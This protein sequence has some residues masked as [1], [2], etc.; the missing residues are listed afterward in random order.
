MTMPFSGYDLTLLNWLNH[1]LIPDSVPVL[2]II[3]LS[4][5][6]ISIS[7][8]LVVL[9]LSI[10]KRSKLLRKQFLILASVLI[11]GAIVTQGLKASIFRDRPFKT[12]PVIEKLSEGGDSSFP[13]GHTIESFA[14]AM[15]LSLLFSKKKTV[16]PVYLWAMTVAYSRM[17]LGVHYPS[18]VLAGVLIGTFIG[19]IIP[20]IFNR[21]NPSG[22]INDPMS[23]PGLS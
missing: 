1:H 17:A 19:W 3:S 13:S 4:T 6:F 15:A 23:Q 2:R 9:M 12:H 8:V 5:T 18:D 11:L 16:I 10:V 21:F 7:L 20:R 14:M 22:K